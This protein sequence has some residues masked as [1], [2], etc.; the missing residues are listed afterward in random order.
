MHVIALEKARLTAQGGRGFPANIHCRRKMH[1]AEQSG[2]RH[3]V[4]RQG[5]NDGLDV[6]KV[7]VVVQRTNRTERNRRPGADAPPEQEH[8]TLLKGRCRNLREQ[9]AHLE[10]RAEEPHHPVAGKSQTKVHAFPDDFDQEYGIEVRLEPSGVDFPAH[11]RKST[12][13]QFAPTLIY[14]N[15]RFCDQFGSSLEC[16]R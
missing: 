15:E 1:P 8:G 11:R 3:A 12:A 10:F 5:Q 2:Y 14:C 9:L 4:I 7:P 6:Q 16:R 13:G